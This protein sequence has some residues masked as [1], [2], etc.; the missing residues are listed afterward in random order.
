M[1]CKVENRRE[2]SGGTCET[3]I[4]KQVLLYMENLITVD[5]LPYIPSLKGSKKEERI[6]KTLDFNILF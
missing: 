2:E 4:Y 6:K 3:K 1:A 5:V